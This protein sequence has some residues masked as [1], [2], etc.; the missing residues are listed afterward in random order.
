M[1]GDLGFIL[2]LNNGLNSTG[3]GGSSIFDVA[4]RYFLG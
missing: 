3:L 4:S 2:G 1:I